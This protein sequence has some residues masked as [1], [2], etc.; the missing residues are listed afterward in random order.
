MQLSR[1]ARGKPRHAS[2]RLTAHHRE[3]GDFFQGQG[4]PA[5]E[6]T[7]LAVEVSATA[8]AT[9]GAISCGCP[10]S[11]ASCPPHISSGPCHPV[12]V[13]AWLSLPTCMQPLHAP[14]VRMDTSLETD[15]VFLFTLHLLSASEP[16]QGMKTTRDWLSPLSP[17]A[18][19]AFLPL[20]SCPARGT[21]PDLIGSS[22]QDGFAPAG[23]LRGSMPD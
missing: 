18:P 13:K 9:A 3:V 11:H 22:L 6:A 7:G 12:L 23:T 15:A 5:A 8:D 21:S 10:V 1:L 20:A 4:V 14:S 17:K 2:C 16:V 19:Q